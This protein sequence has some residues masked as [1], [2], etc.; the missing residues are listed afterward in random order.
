MHCPRDVH[1]TKV[2]RVHVRWI[3]LADSNVYF[4]TFRFLEGDVETNRGESSSS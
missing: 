1:S 2:D 4:A 3:H